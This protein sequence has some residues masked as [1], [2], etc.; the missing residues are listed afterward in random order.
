MILWPALVA[1]FLWLACGCEVAAG[2]E[3]RE[4]SGTNGTE[5][6]EY[7]FKGEGTI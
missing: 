2:Y 1:V 5:K 3:E 6:T 4:S 7:R